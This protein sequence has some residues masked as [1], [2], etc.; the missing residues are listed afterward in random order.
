MRRGA[1]LLAAAGLAAATAACGSFEDP[2]IVLDLRVLAMTAEPP[3]VVAPFDPADPLDV[4]LADSEICALIADPAEDRALT[5]AM[6]ACGPTSSDRCD[7]PLRPVLDLGEQTIEDPEEAASAPRAC[8]TLEDGLGLLAVLQ[9]SLSQD[10]LLGFGGIAARVELRVRPA[11]SEPGG[12]DEIFAFKRMRYAPQQPPERVANA[13]PTLDGLCAVTIA[14][15]DADPVAPEACADGLDP[16]VPALPLGRCAD[17]TPLV[18]GPGE[19]L[20]IFPVEPAGVREDYVLPTFDGGVQAITE[21]LTYAWLATAGS[22]SAG[23]TG[24][25][26]DIAGNE[27]RLET[28]FTAPD[29]PEIIGDG[30]DIALWIVQRD[31]RGGAAWF[32]SCVRVELE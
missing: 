8:A 1:G 21:N 20:E 6:R 26:R 10:D 31:E 27:A 11:D 3:E 32:E 5:I 16:E 19:L 24:G 17:V 2:S 29:D 18:L 13:N 4:E 25:P 14:D 23:S 30:L 9:D 7:D 22:W 15:S 28:R 12:A